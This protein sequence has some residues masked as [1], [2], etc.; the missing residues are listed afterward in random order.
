MYLRSI[1]RDKQSA[2]TPQTKVR[3]G[4]DTDT[5]IWPWPNQ[6]NPESFASWLTNTKD[7]LLAHALNM[8]MHAY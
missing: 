8:H 7:Y 5:L 3:S 6:E 2:W 4:S 1:I